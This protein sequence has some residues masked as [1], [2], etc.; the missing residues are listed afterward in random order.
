MKKAIASNTNS[1]RLYNSC[2]KFNNY[3]M[4]P[5]K[6]DY[7]GITI[8]QRPED[9]YI[10]LNEMAQAT[11]KRV[12]NW[13][14]NKSTQELIAEFNL[15]PSF[16]SSKA[17]ALITDPTNAKY[18][19][20]TWA[21]P[22]IAIQFA[23][24]CSPPFALQVSRWVREWLTGVNAFSQMDDDQLARVEIVSDIA[25]LQ[26]TIKRSQAK[27]EKK[28]RDLQWLDEKIKHK[29]LAIEMGEIIDDSDRNPRK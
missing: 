25:T 10:N 11:N 28:V 6:H 24:W 7:K 27:L 1:D 4:N 17:T 15:E 19:G 13:L 14:Q 2:T 18:G 8:N 23:Q 12:D 21:H 29:Q 9:G 3:I 20:G 22:D 16:N 5:I 26:A